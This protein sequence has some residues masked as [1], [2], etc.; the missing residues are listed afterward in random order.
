MTPLTK[1]QAVIIMAFTGIACCPFSEFHE[2]AEQK[3]GRPIFTHEFGRKEVMEQ[4]K[5][6]CRDD[7]LAICRRSE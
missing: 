1:E 6:V 7:F 5:M 2:Y 3:L 4:L